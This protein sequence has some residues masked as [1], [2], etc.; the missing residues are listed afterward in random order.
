MPRS[1]L[2]HGIL[3]AQ[4]VRTFMMAKHVSSPIKSANAS[5]PIGIFVPS[6]IV[7]SMSSRVPTPVWHA[8]MRGCVSVYIRIPLCAYAQTSGDYKL[9][10]TKR[11]MFLQ[12]THYIRIYLH[13][14][15]D[16]STQLRTGYAYTHA[17][18]VL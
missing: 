11:P 6:F 17:R 14:C 1:L 10:E 4:H 9:M 7:T 5:G 16:E 15:I 13:A 2:L 3:Y 8:C 18:T 12:R